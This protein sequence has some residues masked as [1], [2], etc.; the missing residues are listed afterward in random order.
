[1]EI[2]ISG[3]DK[4][5]LELVKELATKLGLTIQKI[6]SERNLVE[7][8]QCTDELIRIMEEMAAAKSFSSIPNPEQWQH[9][10]REDRTL[11]GR[12]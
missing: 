4:H 3:K 7:E 1:M 6:S 8:E 12:E 2:I 10:I 5:A 11:P 9:E